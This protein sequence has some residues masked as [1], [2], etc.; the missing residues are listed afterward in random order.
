VN[1]GRIAL[2]A[3]GAAIVATTA[4]AAIKTVVVPR[5]TTSIINRT[6][7]IAARKTFEMIAHPRRTYEQRDR[8]LA[9]YAPLSLVM[10]PGMWVALMIVGFTMLFMGISDVSWR[11]AFRLAGSSL[12]TLGFAVR[13]DNPSV[14]L[15]FVAATIGLGL[16]ALLIS[17]LPSIYSSF[18]RREALVA[19]LEVRAGT[20]P[21]AATLLIRYNTIDRLDDIDDDLFAKWEQWFL[22]VE[23]S[24]TS[25]SALVFFRSPRPDRSWITAAGTVLDVAAITH[26]TLDRPPSPAAALCLRT[27]FFCLRRIADFFQ[28]HY[29]PDPQPGDAISVQREEYDAVCRQLEAAGIALKPD[30]DQTWRDFA[31]WRVNYDQVL[32]MIAK[33]VIAPPAPWITDR[34]G[35]RITPRLVRRRSPRR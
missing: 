32:V 8:V 13:T 3:L 30:R 34:P 2:T 15:E 17:Y 6:V 26:S 29:D 31:G 22:D 14:V 16:V 19:S 5:P 27:G 7:F 20:P 21:S 35:P 1:I 4:L 28:I 18:S 24:H 11:D 12:L 9:V 33:M 25:I 23:E 10:L